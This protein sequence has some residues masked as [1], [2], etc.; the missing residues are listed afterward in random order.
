LDWLVG[1]FLLSI[2]EKP[3][4]VGLIDK[5]FQLASNGLEMVEKAFALL[6]CVIVAHITTIPRNYHVSLKTVGKVFY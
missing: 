5:P 4:L 1:F 2:G 3:F 6:S